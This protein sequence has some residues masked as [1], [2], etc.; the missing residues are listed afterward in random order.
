M[1]LSSEMLQ[2]LDN[3]TQV[4]F[5]VEQFGFLTVGVYLLICRHK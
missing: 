1:K 2:Y 3:K 5:L 4:C